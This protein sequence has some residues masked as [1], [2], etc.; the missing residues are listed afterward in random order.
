MSS[1][2]ITGGTVTGCISKSGSAGVS[3]T[4]KKNSLI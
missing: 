4:L 2:G 1:S 3:G